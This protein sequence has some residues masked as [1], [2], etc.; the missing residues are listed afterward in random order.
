MVLCKRLDSFVNCIDAHTQCAF[1]QYL[2]NGKQAAALSE[3]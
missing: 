1:C 2:S 3:R